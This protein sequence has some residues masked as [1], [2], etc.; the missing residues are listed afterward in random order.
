MTYN[1]TRTLIAQL[2]ARL[3]QEHGIR[4]FSQAKRKAARQLGIVDAHHLP[5]NEEIEDAIREYNAV[6]HA[7]TQPELLRELRREALGIMEMLARFDPHLTGAVLNGTASPYSGIQI[8]LFTDNEKE[9]EMYLL[10][11]NLPFRQGQCTSS[12]NLGKRPVPCFILDSG[13]NDIRITVQPPLAMRRSQRNSNEPLRRAS[14]T[15][16]KTLIAEDSAA[17]AQAS[18]SQSAT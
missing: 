11:Q 16:L 13:Q 5:G 8:E 2:A 1:P 4:D 17:I 6:Y 10:N 18:A 3:M 9:V 14:L 12:G 15:Q 7:D